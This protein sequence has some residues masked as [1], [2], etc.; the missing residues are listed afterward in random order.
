MEEYYN[1]LKVQNKLDCSKDDVRNLVEDLDK[2]KEGKVSIKDFVSHPII[3]QAVFDTID[4]NKDGQVSKGELK[5]AAKG[6]SMRELVEIINEIDK[7]NDGLLSFDEVKA[8]SKRAYAIRAKSKPSDRDR[9]K[10]SSSS[11]SSSSK[12]SSKSS[13][14]SSK[15]SSS[16]NSSS[17]RRK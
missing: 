6:M 2:D 5:L 3:S 15:S 11:S 1:V 17:S 14:S 12:S 4:R 8:I 13:S 10:K 7:D 9:D 16:K